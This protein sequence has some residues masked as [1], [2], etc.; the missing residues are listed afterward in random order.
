MNEICIFIG[1]SI[2]AKEAAEILSADYY[3]PAAQGD[4]YSAFESGYKTIGLIDGVFDAVPS[5]WHKEILYC[6]SK[7]AS[8]FGASSMGA[9]RAAELAD[10]GMTG[11]GEIYASYLRGEIED[12]DEVAILHGPK[13]LNC[14]PITIPLINLRF[15]LQA[16]VVQEQLSAHEA[17]LV[18]KTAKNIFYRER[19]MEHLTKHL[20]KSAAIN[21]S[22]AH[23]I[24]EMISVHYIDQKRIDAISLL[25]AIST[26]KTDDNVRE[27][28]RFTFR[29]TIV[30]LNN[31]VN[32]PNRSLIR[33]G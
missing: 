22:R 4:I 12:D 10:Y 8:I 33:H 18:I 1:P 14:I 9:L 6:I 25:E 19:T 26:F 21:C 27:V 13:E 31:M 11:V 3:L 20:E 17:K 24:I 28:P 7:G 2:S 5:V 30:W 23:E 29:E 16:H 32:K 15:T